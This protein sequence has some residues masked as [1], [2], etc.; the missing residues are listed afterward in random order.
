MRGTRLG[1]Q[2]N[3]GGIGH[4]VGIDGACF[5]ERVEIAVDACLPDRER[6]RQKSGRR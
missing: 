6:R 2:R 4:A 5:R 1:H 3:R